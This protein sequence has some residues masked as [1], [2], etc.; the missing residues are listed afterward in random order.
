MEFYD[1]FGRIIDTNTYEPYEQILVGKFVDPDDCVLELG[2]RYGVVSHKINK[3]L[4][5]KEDH[6]AVE[7]DSRVWECLERNRKLYDDQYTII[8]GFLSKAPRE[9][10]GNGC[11]SS[12]YSVA[13][14]STPSFSLEDIRRPRP[15]TMLVIDCEGFMETFIQEFP[16]VFDTC[17]K[18]M[19]EQDRPDLCDYGNVKTFLYEKGF[20]PLIS[21]FGGMQNIWQRE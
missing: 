8:K 21:N 6:V 17:K 11:G 5:N 4:K 19:F 13:S 15:F 1:E 12:S 14:S 9:I 16:E 20:S 2:A 7:P 18:V 10:T 3:M